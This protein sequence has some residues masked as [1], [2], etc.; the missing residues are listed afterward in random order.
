MLE[1]HLGAR[2]A[3]RSPA[4]PGRAR[5][6]GPDVDVAEAA[7]AGADVAADEERRGLLLEALAPVRAARLLA[8]RVEAARR[9]SA[10]SARGGPRASPSARGSTAGARA[11]RAPG[12]AGSFPGDDDRLRLELLRLLDLLR[13]G[14]GLRAV[15]VRA[16]PD[17]EE[18]PSCPG[19]GETSGVEAVRLQLL[20]EAV[21][22][23]GVRRDDDL[24]PEGPVAL[25]RRRP[26]FTGAGAA[27]RPA[28]RGLGRPR[29]RLRVLL[30]RRG[31]SFGGAF[32]STFAGRFGASR[33]RPAS[34]RRPRPRSRSAPPSAPESP[35]RPASLPA[36]RRDRRC[37]TAR[38]A[39]R[40]GPARAWPRLRSSSRRRTRGRARRGGRG[41]TPPPGGPVTETW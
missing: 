2:R 37:P 39:P 33:R 14:L 24:D 26:S 15:G 10:S 22:L 19:T 5:P 35:C 20:R 32:S 8:D 41:R 31:S 7:G 17:P 6:A 36:D 40:P 23:L 34:A 13:G 1:P 21:G 38:R 11:R 3:R 16:D 25:L 18:A 27:S 30:R 29:R 12:A 9:A 4:P 28:S